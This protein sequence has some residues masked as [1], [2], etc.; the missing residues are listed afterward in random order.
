MPCEFNDI[1][2]F[3]CNS[4]TSGGL[5]QTTW[6]FNYSDIVDK[7]A[8]LA[9]VTNIGVAM[10]TIDIAVGEMSFIKTAPEKFSFTDTGI[11]DAIGRVKAYDHGFDST[12]Y[13]S[14]AAGDLS[15]QNLVESVGLIFI[16]QT[17]A[18]EF[19]IIGGGGNGYVTSKVQGSGNAAGDDS[20]NVI[21]YVAKNQSK[22]VQRFSAGTVAQTVAYLNGL[23][24]P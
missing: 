23:L 16:V 10:A 14:G 2:D 4:K 6:V 24:V 20:G 1:I 18:D 15:I 5:K 12:L 8:F 19:L 3:N 22:P 13:S 9:D 11:P 7:E 17:L 21:T